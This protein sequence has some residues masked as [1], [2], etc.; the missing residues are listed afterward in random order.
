VPAVASDVEDDPAREGEK[1]PRA[2]DQ[3]HGLHVLAPSAL[4]LEDAG[5]DKLGDENDRLFLLRPGVEAQLDR[6]NRIL[7]RA[8]LDPHID[9][10]LDFR[11][12]AALLGGRK[13]ARIFE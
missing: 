8:R 1:Q 4:Q 5:V 9:P 12:T 6:E 2:F 7:G 11:R 3:Q 10:K 13:Q